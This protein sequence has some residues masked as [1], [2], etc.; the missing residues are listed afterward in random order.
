MRH[1]PLAIATRY[2]DVW[3][4]ADPAE[5][6]Q[7]VEHLWMPDGMHFTPTRQF[8]GHR[9]LETRVLEAYDQF[10]RTK[11]YIFRVFG[12]PLGHHNVVKL[13]W[14]MQH[15]VTGAVDAYGSDVLILSDDGR[16]VTDFQFLEASPVPLSDGADA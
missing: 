6:R 14:K 1:E 2:I 10:V 9:A 12:Q 5:R 11:G 3:N 4:Q 8:Q 15:T 16:I 7:G 13:Q